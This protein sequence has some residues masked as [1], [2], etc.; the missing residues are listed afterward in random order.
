MLTAPLGWSESGFAFRFV[1]DMIYMREFGQNAMNRSLCAMWIGRLMVFTGL[2]F[3][4][5]KLFSPLG[6]K[7]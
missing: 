1:L 3:S 5:W 4:S 7:D 2:G 6:R